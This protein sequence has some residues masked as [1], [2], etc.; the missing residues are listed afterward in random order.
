[1]LTAKGPGDGFR[2]ITL[3]RLIGRV[4]AVD[5]LADTLLPVRGARVGVSD[6]AVR[7]G[8]GSRA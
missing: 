5:V 1:M 8:V 2:P 7:D 3:A 6:K 4:A